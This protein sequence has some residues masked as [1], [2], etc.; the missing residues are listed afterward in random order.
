MIGVELN[1]LDDLNKNV[2]DLM[3]T[4]LSKP[5]RSK[6]TLSKLSGLRPNSITY[7]LTGKE[8]IFNKHPSK[9]IKLLAILENMEMTDVYKKYQS[10]ISI[11]EKKC[12][13]HLD[14]SVDIDIE[15]SSNKTFRR[16]FVEAMGNPVAAAIFSLAL[17][18]EGVTE[19]EINKR[20]GTY[21]REVIGDLVKK[22]ILVSARSEGLR[23]FAINHQLLHLERDDIKKIIPTFNTF[24]NSSH[25][26]QERN[27]EYFRLDTINKS[28]LIKIYEAYADLNMKVESILSS[29]TS[30][31]EIPF[32]AFAQLDTL[33]DDI[34]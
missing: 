1:K 9:V 10:E 5:K 29:P 8:F 11:I 32:Y 21:S 26:G 28:T 25:A 23:Y 16:D 31:G 33:V 17:R 27:Y 14:N 19:Q 13:Q 30:R 24:Y 12:N 2:I 18:E 22:K 20:Y 3:N 6:L 34:D 4:W 7:L 15:L